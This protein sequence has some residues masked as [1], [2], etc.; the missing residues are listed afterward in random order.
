MD[1]SRSHRARH[2]R[3]V[4][5]YRQRDDSSDPRPPPLRTHYHC[6]TRPCWSA[7]PFG[8]HRHSCRDFRHRMHSPP[9]PPRTLPLH[10]R[11]SDARGTNDERTD[12]SRNQNI[13]N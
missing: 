5:T 3:R 4:D 11:T 10:D 12:L 2:G 9:C 13:F 7:R 8:T 6:L 1:Q